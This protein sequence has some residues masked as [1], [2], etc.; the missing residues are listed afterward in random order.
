MAVSY[1]V[2]CIRQWTQVEPILKLANTKMSYPTFEMYQVTILLFD[3]FR[4][5]INPLFL[6]YL[7]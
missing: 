4:A 5:A 7:F 2:W 6:Y 1:R 3:V